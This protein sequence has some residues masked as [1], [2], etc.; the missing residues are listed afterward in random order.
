MVFA[1]TKEQRPGGIIV[2]PAASNIKTVRCGSFCSAGF[3]GILNVFREGASG[4]LVM[5][6]MKDY[7]DYEDY[8]DYGDYEGL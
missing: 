7:E 6:I 5:R 8:E 1:A 2:L 3:P 4:G